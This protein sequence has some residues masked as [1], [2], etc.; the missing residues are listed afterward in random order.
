MKKSLCM[1]VLGFLLLAGISA[2]EIL[3]KD[4]SGV[5]R[6]YAGAGSTQLDGEAVLALNGR[7]SYSLKK[8]LD[9]GVQASAYHTLEREYTDDLGQS[10]QAESGL[11]GLFIRP[12]WDLTQRLNMGITVS[13]GMQMIQL[14]YSS[15]Y[16]DQ[17]VWTE[18][19]PDQLQLTYNS[20]SLSMEYTLCPDHSLFLEGG[21]RQLHPFESPYLSRENETGGIFGGL[22]YGLKL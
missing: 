5:F 21:F 19:I 11:S 17:M 8:W 13:S 22:Y 18:E 12:N 20:L 9:L 7:I 15:E 3:L 10:Y 14:R 16:R 1:V 4:Q 2:E 6:I